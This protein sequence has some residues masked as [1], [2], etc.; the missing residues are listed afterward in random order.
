MSARPT[1]SPS[2]A[3]AQRSTVLTQKRMPGCVAGRAAM[4]LSAMPITSAITMLG[5]GATWAT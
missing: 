1:R 3:T 4:G 5:I 2:S